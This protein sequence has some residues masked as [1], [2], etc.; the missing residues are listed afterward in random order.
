MLDELTVC[1]AVLNPQSAYYK[2]LKQKWN[3]AFDDNYWPE[4]AI[5]MERNSRD[6]AS[7][8]YGI[9][10]NAEAICDLLQ[11]HP[12]SKCPSNIIFGSFGRP[13]WVK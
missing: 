13:L 11:A 8:I 10:R 4:D 3:E 9:N 1:S 5:Y 7:R 6:F 12:K 2:I